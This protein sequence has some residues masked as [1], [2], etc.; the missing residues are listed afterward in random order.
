MFTTN[1]CL[2]IFRLG[3]PVQY[4]TRWPLLED[5]VAVLP[6]AG[7]STLGCSDLLKEAGAG[8][9]GWSEG[10][11]GPGQEAAG[12]SKG[13]CEAGGDARSGMQLLFFDTFSHDAGVGATSELNLDLVQFPS[14]VYVSEVCVIPIPASHAC[15][16]C[17]APACS[18]ATPASTPGACYPPRLTSDRQFSRRSQV[19]GNQPLLLPAGTFREQFEGATPSAPYLSNVTQGPWGLHL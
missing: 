10:T 3:S 6:S 12:A 5:V 14:P 9:G 11:R 2:P 8:A 17:P 1:I 16:S 19:G 15:T 4:L 18:P 13:R 7:T